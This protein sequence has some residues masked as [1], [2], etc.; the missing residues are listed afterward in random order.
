MALS[1][2]D[3]LRRLIGTTGA[4]AVAPLAL[5]LPAPVAP[6]PATAAPPPL[7]AH[8]IETLR[9]TFELQDRIC[10]AVQQ[11]QLRILQDAIAHDPA[12]LRLLVE[13]ALISRETAAVKLGLTLPPLREYWHASRSQP[14]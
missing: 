13:N 9:K 7:P 1:R 6:P 4:L 14:S 11:E 3:F 10:A 8:A 12:T 2:R 5:R